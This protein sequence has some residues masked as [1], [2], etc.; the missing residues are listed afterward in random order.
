MILPFKCKIGQGSHVKSSVSVCKIAG[1]GPE[2]LS[3]PRRFM[4]KI[5][6][7][8]SPNHG[9]RPLPQLSWVLHQVVCADIDGDGDDEFLVAMMG[10][11]PADLQRTGVWCYKLVDK[12]NMKFSKTKLSSVS[13]G[14]IVT[15]N[16]HSTGS[17]VDI[18]TISYSVPGYFESPNPSINVLFSTGILAERLDEEVMSR[19]VRASSTRFTTE[20][21]FLD[22]SGKRLTLVVLPPCARLAVEKGVSGVKVMAGTLSWADASGTHERAPAARPFSAES[23]VVT[24]PHVEAGEEGAIFVLLK[25][26]STSGHP[27]FSAMSQLVAHNIFP[28]YVPDDVRAM[29]FPWVRCADRPWAHGRFKG[30]EFFNLVGFHVHFAD[31]SAGALAHV[32]L[33]TAGVGVSAGFHNHVEASFCEIHACIANGT[34]RGGMRWATGPDADFD[35]DHPD[36][37]HTELVVVP[38]MH[39]HGPL[40]R[41]RPDGHPFLRVNDTIDYP[42]HAWLAGA[43]NPDPQAFDVWLAFE[44]PAFETFSTPAP[45]HVLAPGQYAIHFAGAHGAALALQGQDATDGTPVVASMDRS[46]PQLWNVSSVPGTDM[47]EIAHA[48]TGSLVCARW[49]PVQ[50]QR[51]VGTHSP[52]AMGLTSRWAVSKNAGGQI[53][54][55]LPEAPGQG[56]L[57]LSVSAAR[58]PQGAATFPVIVQGDNLELSAWT[59]TPAN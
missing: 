14:R 8:H 56:P 43:G 36:L 7:L 57:F 30:L 20:M 21:E 12:E 3:K 52:A 58:E 35:P 4:P 48:R 26:S 59:L 50:H 16:F 15:A 51:V 38:A 22:V 37:A 10:A 13:A 39:E 28:R 53:S 9:S 45:P 34:G 42:W 29:H 1:R 24:A 6:G 47:Y 2:K 31:D 49:P 54:F 19:V 41:T 55:R 18:A 33:W 5:A 17:E 46:V 40:W 32:Q 23:M 27:P 11:D 44:F 25:P